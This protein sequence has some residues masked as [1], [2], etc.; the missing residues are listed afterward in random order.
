MHSSSMRLFREGDGHNQKLHNAK[1]KLVWFNA[2]M[3]NYLL[4][5]CANLR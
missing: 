5:K 3:E 1:T 2:G 4:I